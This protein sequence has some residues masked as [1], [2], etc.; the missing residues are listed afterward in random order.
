MT[1]KLDNNQKR[2][3]IVESI[4]DDIQVP[5][6]FPHPSIHGAVSGFHSKL[7][8]KKHSDSFYAT[9][10]TPPEL[11]SR[12]LRCDDIA[13]QLAVRALESSVGKRI[14]MTEL[15]ILEQYL[16]RLVATRWTTEP[17]ARFIIRRTAQI[18]GWPVPLSARP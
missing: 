17:E 3:Q 2:A 13:Q 12:W 1:T 16:P 10:C 11:Y 5:R 9:G 8:L 14:H 7:L 18:L 15:A 4:P 6:D